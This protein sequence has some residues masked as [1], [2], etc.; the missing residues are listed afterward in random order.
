[1][2]MHIK[3]MPAIDHPLD[4]GEGWQCEIPLRTWKPWRHD[5]QFAFVV[6]F[7]HWKWWVVL[8]SVIQAVMA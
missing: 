3:H 1:M 2:K 7:H 6:N 4:C 5:L 8:K